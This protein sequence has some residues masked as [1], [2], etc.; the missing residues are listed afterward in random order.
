M[1]LTG[2]TGIFVFRKVDL[3]V[4]SWNQ[5]CVIGRVDNHLSKSSGG[6]AEGNTHFV[7]LPFRSILRRMLGVVVV[8]LSR[9]WWNG[10]SSIDQLVQLAFLNQFRLGSLRTRIASPSKDDFPYGSKCS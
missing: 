3:R 6:N 1:I 4:R 7:V 2:Y 8:E 9:T 5:L 10:P